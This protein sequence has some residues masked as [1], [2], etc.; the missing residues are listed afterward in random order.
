[1]SG[2][3]F[4]QIPIATTQDHALSDGAFR[5]FAYLVWR[6]GNKDNSWP[7]VGTMAD[8]LGVSHDT[9]TRRVKELE[10]AGYIEVE[11][12]PGKSSL[13][14]V[15]GCPAEVREGKTQES[16][17]SQ[18]KDAV[19][20]DSHERESKNEIDESTP[21]PEGEAAL[22]AVFG[23]RETPIEEIQARK[24]RS[25]EELRQELVKAE[26]RMIGRLADMPW[27]E[28]SDGKFKPW[29][30]VPVDHQERVAWLIERH[31]RLMP[32]AGDWRFWGECCAQVYL[33]GGGDWDVIEESIKAVWGREPQ[34]RPGHAKGFIDE[35]RKTQAIGLQD[36]VLEVPGW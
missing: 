2:W 11:R 9:I 18:R 30:G 33:A 25:E 35:A 29:Q 5:L 24:P 22:T 4:S 19:H 27:L 21:E 32:T 14:T 12:R 36:E 6:Q 28:W 3:T 7:L 8:D 17:E 26:R 16:G 20:N 23:P 13:Y 1:M 31:T 15:T 34:Y 10:D